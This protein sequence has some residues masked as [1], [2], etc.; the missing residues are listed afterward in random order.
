MMSFKR[1]P[2]PSRRLAEWL[3]LLSAL[4]PLGGYMA[5]S[6]HQ[7]Y[8]A[9]EQ[10]ERER[11]AGQAL[12][13]ERNLVRQIAATKNALDSIVE[14]LPAWKLANDGFKVGNRRLGV[15]SGALDGIRNILITDADGRVIASNKT[16]SIGRDLSDRLFFQTPA[17]GN[18]P[19]TLYVAPPYVTRNGDY[20][21]SLNRV[22][23]GARGEFGGVVIAGVDPEY[24][25][26]L[27]DSTRYSP[28]VQVSLAHGDGVFFM[29]APARVELNGKDLARPGSLFARYRSGGATEAV[30]SG[31]SSLTGE[32]RLIAFRTIQ[33][34]HLHMDKPLVVSVSRDTHS[35][36]ATL[37]QESRRDAMLF[38]LIALIAMVSLS[39]YQRRRLA[40]DELAQRHELARLQAE[41][42][43][44][45]HALH[46]EVLSARMLQHREHEKKSIAFA[47]HE[48][49]A[50]TLSALKMRV[51]AASLGLSTPGGGPVAGLEPMVQTMK[52]A[53]VEVRSLALSLRPSS[54]DDLGLSATIRWFLRE[55]EVQHPGVQTHADISV[56][57][58][59]IPQALRIIIFR[60]MEEVCRA[61]GAC[62]SIH[63]I[64]L[65]IQA[66]DDRI[67]LMLEYDGPRVE[68]AGASGGD[69]LLDASRELA[70]L[71]GGRFELSTSD[72][73]L[74]RVQASW[75]M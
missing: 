21:M 10:R 18:D 16:D 42:E 19:K 22:I 25:K 57:D 70:I 52:D 11:L 36:F 7:A 54:L 74:H 15:L 66:Q 60:M 68:P 1:I 38:C 14:D 26:T 28:G 56:D 24:F 9:T 45:A 47:L 17:R 67:V 53:I 6:L 27:L 63:H 8:G 12:I 58:A 73:G 61:F 31:L 49:V 13:V 23:P 46:L 37:D 20:V 2:T 34:A 43:L 51:E 29:M 48:G 33:P 64:L 3:L 40:Y 62:A 71:S 75:L 59:Q 5:Y 55:Y 65:T 72:E 39:V 4:L 35:I 30:F 32:H 41:S 44:R 50:Q 69:A